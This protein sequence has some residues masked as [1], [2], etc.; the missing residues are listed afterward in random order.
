MTDN[1]KVDLTEDRV[2]FLG[3]GLIFRVV[4]APKAWNREQ[5]EGYVTREDPPGTS[6]NRWVIS[7]ADDDRTDDWKGCNCKDCPDDADRQHW[8]MNC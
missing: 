6:A 2:F 4:C 3:W 7:E 1:T 5:I 8:L